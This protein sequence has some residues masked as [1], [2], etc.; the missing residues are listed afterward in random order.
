MGTR[1]IGEKIGCPAT[2]IAPV[3]GKSRIDGK[4]AVDGQSDQ[5]AATPHFCQSIV[6]FDSGKP[7]LVGAC[8]LADQRFAGTLQWRGKGE[9]DATQLTLADGGLGGLVPGCQG[10]ASRTGAVVPMAARSAHA[11]C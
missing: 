9:L 3:S 4:A 5:V 1:H 6:V 10:G 2:A 8:I 7:I 11:G